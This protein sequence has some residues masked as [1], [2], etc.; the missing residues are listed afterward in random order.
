MKV[1]YNKAL[2]LKLNEFMESNNI[3]Q[4]KVAPMIGVS[5]SALSQWRNEK[6][7][8]GNPSEIEAKVQEFLRLEEEK[9]QEKAKALK[10][11][12]RALNGYI[13]TSIS[14]DIYKLIKFCHFE[15]GMIVAHG[16]AGI[17]KT[18]GAEKYYKENPTSTIYIQATPS[19]GT[20]NSLLKLLARA[21][22]INE[23]K[24][25]LDLILEI[26]E[27][28]ETND[29]IIII[30]EAQHLKLG[31]LEEI[32]TLADPSDILESKGTGIVL[33]GNTEV[34]NKMLGKQEARFAQ[35][36]SRIRLNKHYTTD[37]VKKED[38]QLM[39]P[40]V[41]E[42]GVIKFLHGI[43]QSKWG[44]RGAVNVY[45]NAVSSEDVSLAGLKNMAVSMGMGLG[46]GLVS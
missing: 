40:K 8:R 35:I 12:Y 7:E 2:I 15:K 36:F 13:P 41:T 44:L 10:N 19:S 1:E 11:Q 16:D 20:L 18:K 30:D 37:K 46:A 27:K 29:K 39:F 23:K 31:A 33:I 34:Y 21:L 5:S 9:A 25:K 43:S 3:S 38:I 17:G 45:N 6:Y 32:R 28:L 24:P 42:D 22:K 4:S 14:E 26:K